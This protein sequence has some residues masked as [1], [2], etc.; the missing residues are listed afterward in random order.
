M[1][2]FDITIAGE[3]NLDLVLYGLP[4]I[5]PLE[6]EMLA[7]GFQLTLGSSSAILAHN[8]AVLGRKVGFISLIGRDE[9]GMIA[10][11]RLR[12]CGVDVSRVR[13]AES[14]T[15]TGVTVLLHH[16]SERRILTYP[17]TMAEMSIDD[18]DID[19][20]SHSRH[21]HLS[22]L[23]LHK[24]LIADIPDLLRELKG[25]GLTLSLDTNDDPDDIWGGVLPQILPLIDILFPNERELLRIACE[26]SMESALKMLSSVVPM[27][28]VKRGPQGCLLQI[29]QDRFAIPAIQVTPVDSIGAGDSFNS[30]FLAAWLGGK[31]AA[32]A[33][34]AGNIAGALSVLRPGGTEA[35]RDRALSADFFS[36]HGAPV[37]VIQEWRLRA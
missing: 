4:E 26:S 23:F 34:R 22:S 19:Y 21:F 31:S 14:S 10:L 16:G 1:C 37:E 13:H 32:D 33:A 24:A 7:S 12:E 25:R 8:L 29:G 3:L 27:I 11:D 18:L 36:R 5:L 15:G 30:G 9:I 6:H 35:F 2:K 28:V 17:G 20:L